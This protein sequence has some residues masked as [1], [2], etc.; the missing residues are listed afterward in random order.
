MPD[1]SMANDE[2]DDLLADLFAEE[3][4][5]RLT[6]IDGDG[7]PAVAPVWFEWD[8]QSL[9]GLRPGASLTTTSGFRRRCV[10]ASRR[11][12]STPTSPSRS[13]VRP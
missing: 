5:L 13:R 8:G 9:L 12:T 6:T 11:G 10:A 7:W 3:R 1:L 4:V 2:L